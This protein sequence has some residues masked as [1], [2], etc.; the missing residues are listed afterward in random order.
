[1]ALQVTKADGT[2][3]V[4]TIDTTNSRWG[5]GTQAPTCA[6]DLVRED[7]AQPMARRVFHDYSYGF[8]D[9][10]VHGHG[11]LAS[12]T[13]CSVGDSIYDGRYAGYD[14]GNAKRFAANTIIEIQSVTATA[15]RGKHKFRTADSAGTMQDRM[16]IDQDGAI[17]AVSL[18]SAQPTMTHHLLSAAVSVTSAATTTVF[19]PKTGEEWVVSSPQLVIASWSG[20]STTQ[21]V[22]GFLVGSNFVTSQTLASSYNLAVDAGVA[23][24]PP[25]N[26]LRRIT[27]T[28]PLKLQVVTAASGGSVSGTVR[29][30]CVLV[31]V[32]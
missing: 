4:A 32:R 28:N 18:V 31:R 23:L 21:A 1:M 12:P 3:A 17:Q 19:T 25:A 11:T 10:I 9:E 14:T 8:V 30:V 26:P 22:V 5:W 6:F 7:A 24:T 2:T 29:L 16:T 27:A 15:V 20:T 13:A